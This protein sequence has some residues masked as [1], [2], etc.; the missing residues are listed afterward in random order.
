MQK[1]SQGGILY[2]CYILTKTHS[3][4]ARLLTWLK[5][6]FKS[7]LYLWQILK[8]KVKRIKHSSELQIR[9]SKQYFSTETICMKCQ[10]LFSRKSKKNIISLSSA[11]SADSMVRVKDN[12]SNFWIDCLQ[13]ILSIHTPKFS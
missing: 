4:G 3:H 6:Y 9:G 7:M 8:V 13:S 10:I 11:E 1:N 5:I 2:L 12:F